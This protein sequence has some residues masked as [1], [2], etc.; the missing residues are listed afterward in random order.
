MFPC[1]YKVVVPNKCK[2]DKKE[3]SEQE[4]LERKQKEEGVWRMYFDGSMAK[5]G[6]G[7]HVYIISPIKD[8]NAYSYKLV[9]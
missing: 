8:F 4:A 1:D 5:V 2:K 6:A 3:I 7:T 9:F